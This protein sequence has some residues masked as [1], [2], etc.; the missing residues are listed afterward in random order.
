MQIWLALRLP[1]PHVFGDELLYSELARSFASGGHFAVRGVS[2]TSYGFGYPLLIAPA[3]A[4]ARSLPTA[5]VL[6]KAIN[7]LLMSLAAVPAWFLARR[8]VSRTGALWAAALAVAV[9]SVVYSGFVMTESAFY[10]A[11][12][13]AV[14]AMLRAL[15]R[16][17]VG[18]QLAVLGAM[19]LAFAIRAQ[20]IVLVPAYLMAVV[21]LRILENRSRRSGIVRTYGVTWVALA[22]SLGALLVVQLG[23]GRSPLQF[24][25]AYRS[26]VESVSLSEA[27]RWFQYLLADFDLYLGIVPF[28]A[29]LV[30]VVPAIRGRCGPPLRLFAVAAVSIALWLTLQVAAFSTAE[31]S[32]NRI[33]ERNLFYVAPLFLIIFLAW[34]ERGM[35]RPRALA[36]PAVA[37]AALLPATLPYARLYGVG[38][39]DALALLPW[40]TPLA[41][42]D[43]VPLLMAMFGVGVGMLFLLLPRRRSGVL[44]G[45]V[46][47]TFA[48]TG[49]VSSWRAQVAARDLGG[50]RVH[51]DWIDAAVGARS[52]VAAPWL[53]NPVVCAPVQR[54]D[55]R[56]R[57]LWE[58]EFFNRSIRATYFVIEPPPDSLPARRLVLD[59]RRNLIAGGGFAP[60]YV[61]VDDSVKLSAPV[62]ARDSQTRT[63]LYRVRGSLR[64]VALPHCGAR[65]LGPRG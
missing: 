32:L 14:L 62:V 50:V 38:D 12:L 22:P 30:F 17:S 6:V 33:H 10:P 11:F 49:I 23:R 53:P 45:I 57:A 31:E 7:A 55:L 8:A 64:L 28:A 59:P 29:F 35:P 48:I 58:N 42:R 18:R 20:A 47:A 46:V 52:E 13:L 25:G 19:A 37:L 60:R 26:A 61:A 24:L 34:I 63:A 15:E 5:Y 43:A 2:T 40:S 51:R 39:V 4:L 21:W 41:S 56:Q 44:L 27:P 3:F 9:P 54:W 36:I 65:S 1:A 16:R